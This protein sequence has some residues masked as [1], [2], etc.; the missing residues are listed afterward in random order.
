M[1]H[2]C[3]ITDVIPPE[4]E[5]K[6]YPPVILFQNKSLCLNAHTQSTISTR[7]ILI[8]IQINRHNARFK[9]AKKNSEITT[10][11]AQLKVRC[12][13][14]AAIYWLVQVKSSS[15]QDQA[16]RYLLFQHHLEYINI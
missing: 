12:K 5:C 16:L 11:V 4:T 13:R 9:L 1:T 15:L 3:K 7:E 2:N 6:L 8:F 10:E 14:F